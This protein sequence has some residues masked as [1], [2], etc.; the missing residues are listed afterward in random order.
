MKKDQRLLAV[1]VLNKFDNTNKKLQLVRDQILIS[2]NSFN[3]SYVVASTNDIIRLKGRLDLLI[4]KISKKKLYQINK[5]LINILRLGFYEILYCAKIPKYATVNS[6]VNLAKSMTN[7]KA[8]GYI[9]F[10]LRKLI[11]E[12]EKKDIFEKYKKLSDWNSFPQW[13]QKRWEKNFGKDNCLRLINYFNRKQGLYVRIN[14]NVEYEK[15]L[16]SLYGEGLSFEV[17][18]KNFIRFDNG[19]NQLLKTSQFKNGL[20]SI[21]DPAAGAVVNLLDL[22]KGDVVL[23]VCAAPGTKSFYISEI[24]GPE[25]KVYAY[26]SD[27]Q[28]IKIAKSDSSRNSLNNII[29]KKKD[30]KIDNYPISKK[31]LV[32]VPCTGTGVLGKKPDIKWRRNPCDID[33]MS[34]LQFQ[35]LQNM[36]KFLEIGGIIIYSTC[37]LEKEENWDVVELFLKYNVNFKLVK[38]TNFLYPGWIDLNG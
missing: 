33:E 22:N 10:I 21:Q 16:G 18:S 38:I 17:F 15:I 14:S 34:Q 25:G 30:A 9:N 19:I 12:I 3:K 27:E 37:S 31:I 8:A 4:F 26:D 28:R 7:R 20:I 35:I 5:K 13:M 11:L 23:D 32:D 2:L 24:I 6:L 1:K 36:S 29:W